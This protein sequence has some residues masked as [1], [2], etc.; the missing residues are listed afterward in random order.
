MLGQLYPANVQPAWGDR[1]NVSTLIAFSGP[2]LIEHVSRHPPCSA[3]YILTM[4]KPREKTSRVDKDRDL[5]QGH[6]LLHRV[7][8]GPHSVYKPQYS[9]NYILLMF[10]LAWED[11]RNLAS[12]HLLRATFV[13]PSVAH[14]SAN[15]FLPI[16][17]LR[18]AQQETYSLH[19]AF[20]L[21]TSTT[22]H[23]GLSGLKVKPR[24]R[25]NT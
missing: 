23:R 4:F 22:R 13:E 21:Q 11:Q 12:L 3:N 2:H 1:Q 14:T 15:Y 19:F 24:R 6:N 9:A 8:T 10:Q 7:A 17:K 16:L 5:I 25:P 18:L 20:V